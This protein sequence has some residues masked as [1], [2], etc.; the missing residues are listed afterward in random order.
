MA[1]LSRYR[2]KLIA[3]R[4]QPRDG[5]ETEIGQAHSPPRAVPVQ[6]ERRMIIRKV[7]I[8]TR[9]IGVNT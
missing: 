2:N 9:T 8:T 4:G 3:A 1:T 7:P 5:R 6:A